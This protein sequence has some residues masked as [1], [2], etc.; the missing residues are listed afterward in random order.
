VSQGF[1]HVYVTWLVPLLGIDRGA[2]E[3]DDLIKNGQNIV[4]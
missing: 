2:S 3:N 1:E 4:N